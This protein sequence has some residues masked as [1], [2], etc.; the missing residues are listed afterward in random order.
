MLL[1]IDNLHRCPLPCAA[2]RK[3]FQG[4]VISG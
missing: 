1:M 2:M 4:K 3:L